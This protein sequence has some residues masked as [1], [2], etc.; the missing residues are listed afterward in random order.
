MKNSQ[1]IFLTVMALTSACTH[2][3]AP[4][5]NLSTNKSTSIIGGTAATN[6]DL[7]TASTVSLII[8]YADKPFSVC[9]GTLVSKNLILT[10]THCLE[11]MG[12][13]VVSIYAGAQLPE[14]YD[15][16]KLLKVASWK[17]H[18]D[19]ELILDDED[20]PVTGVNDVALMKL[21]EDIPPHLKPVPIVSNLKAP[22]DGSSL[23]LAGYGLINELETPVYATGL[24][25]VRVP[26]ANIW[27]NILVTDQNDGHG[28]CSGDSGGPAYIETAQ[29]L[30]V[31]GITRGP[32]DK[33][34]DC[35]HY[36]EYTYASRFET[37]ILDTAK[38]LGG[39]T[40]Q[41]VDLAE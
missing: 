10:A 13:G 40:P 20:Y 35:R 19:Y 7:V 12:E 17:T 9:T 6:S 30:A 29:G 33:V 15:E 3:E 11:Y 31:I 25:Y 5:V 24:N 16:T 23:L 21:A 8:N 27:N 36:G 28:A 32:H 34:T 18:P 4:V 26:L 41:F 1:L 2:S 37:F 14:V 39:E 22:K 38:E